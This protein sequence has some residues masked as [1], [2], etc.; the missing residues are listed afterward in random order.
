MA[1]GITASEL[2]TWATDAGMP[3]TMVSPADMMLASIENSR[4]VKEA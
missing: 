4:K 3:S 2:M 1:M